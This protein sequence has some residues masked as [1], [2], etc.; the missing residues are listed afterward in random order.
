MATTA[1]TTT[2]QKQHQ[3]EEQHEEDSARGSILRQIQKTQ[4]KTARRSSISGRMLETVKNLG[5]FRLKKDTKQT[6]S[7]R[8]QSILD[9]QRLAG[10]SRTHTS[11]RD[12]AHIRRIQQAIGPQISFHDVDTIVMKD[13]FERVE[14][15]VHLSKEE[16]MQRAV[17]L[18][19]VAV[20]GGHARTHNWEKNK[21][22]VYLLVHSAPYKFCLTFVAFLHMLMS[23]FEA[24]SN[25]NLSIFEEGGLRSTTQWKYVVGFEGVLVAVYMLDVALVAYHEGWNKGVGSLRSQ[26]NKRFW[27]NALLT[28]LLALDWLLELTM[29]VPFVRLRPLRAF[30]L[31]IR[32]NR[33]FENSKA[34]FATIPFVM[35]VILLGFLFVLVCAMCALHLFA[36]T[37]EAYPPV[38]WHA[39]FTIIKQCQAAGTNATVELDPPFLDPGTLRYDFVS[40]GSSMMTLLTLAVLDQWPDIGRPAFAYFPEFT[41]FF[42]MFIVLLTAVITNFPVASILEAFRNMK[43]KSVLASYLRERECLALA[44]CTLVD[45]STAASGLNFEDFE[46]LVVNMGH[47]HNRARFLFDMVDADKSQTIDQEEFFQLSEALLF[48]IPSDTVHALHTKRCCGLVPARSSAVCTYL[49]SIRTTVS[50]KLRLEKL[51]THWSFNLLVGLMI[52]LNGVVMGLH[53]KGM[54]IETE[55]ALER[56]DQGM[57]FFFAAEVVIKVMALGSDRYWRDK[58]NRFDF[59]LVVLAFLMDFVLYLFSAFIGDTTED[60]GGSATSVTKTARVVRFTKVGKVWKMFRIVKALR[61]IRLMRALSRLASAV[62]RVDEIVSKLVYILP[63]LMDVFVILGILFYI[64]TVAGMEAFSEF[65]ADGN[66]AQYTGLPP[67]EMINFKSFGSSA[68]ALFQIYSTMSFG[69][70]LHSLTDFIHPQSYHTWRARLFCFSFYIITV[71]LLNNLLLALVLDLFAVLSAEEKKVTEEKTKKQLNDSS[72]EGGEALGPMS[73][74]ASDIA[75]EMGEQEV[76]HRR[77]NNSID[78]L[79]YLQDA[80]IKSEM[81]RRS[82]EVERLTSITLSMRQSLE[83]RAGSGARGGLPSMSAGSNLSSFEEQSPRVRNS[84]M[85]SD[86]GGQ[87]SLG[88]LSRASLGLPSDARE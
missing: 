60:L 70:V 4:R 40:L 7:V 14:D 71:L 21:I 8:A 1:T 87:K 83:S 45:H 75:K 66:T 39:N 19:K 50:T 68:T 55:D 59:A 53:K 6:Y 65:Y 80:S 51:I 13:M 37:Y 78:R 26:H 74:I 10:L 73:D 23:Q 28:A 41:I 18:V 77:N 44:Y 82:K 27:A 30:K 33:I 3:K 9:N 12:Y 56:Y 54:D 72:V 81:D 17:I 32:S 42:C 61:V 79:L 35:D 63:R 67:D 62:G 52:V 84:S 64:W 29:M 38:E 11:S 15:L 2:G 20:R 88:P 31:G 34:L 43:S 86:E 49:T 57:L 24:P 25:T 16:R 22:K 76:T 46:Q 85:G 36:D 47:S 69:T 5:S 58:W 48:S